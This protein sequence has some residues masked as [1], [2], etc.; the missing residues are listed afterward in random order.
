MF[1]PLKQV[2]TKTLVTVLAAGYVGALLVAFFPA[3]AP[4]AVASKLKGA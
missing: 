2:D 1:N 4:E 3:L